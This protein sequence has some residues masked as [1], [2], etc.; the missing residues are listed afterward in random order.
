M[1]KTPYI[2]IY[3]NYYYYVAGFKQSLVNTKSFKK[4][5]IIPC[6]RYASTTVFLAHRNSSKGEAKEGSRYKNNSRRS[7]LNVE[8]RNLGTIGV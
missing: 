8:G 2:I 7:L 5:R 6:T 3:V 4:K 1:Y